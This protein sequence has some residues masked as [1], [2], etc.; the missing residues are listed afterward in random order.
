MRLGINPC[1][2]AFNTPHRADGNPKSAGKGCHRLAVRHP[3]FD[4]GDGFVRQDRIGGALASQRAVSSFGYT[5]ASVV[6]ISAE[7]EMVGPNTRTIVAAMEYVQPIGDG[8]KGVLV[9]ESVRC[10]RAP[11]QFESPISEA[12]RSRRPHPTFTGL[13]DLR[14]EPFKRGGRGN[15]ISAAVFAPSLVVHEAP[16]KGVGFTRAIVNGTSKLMWHRISNR[17]GVA[18]QA[19]ATALP[20]HCTAKLGGEPCHG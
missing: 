20:L 19:D 17:F 12:T 9:A 11:V 7:E 8:A 15:R 10:K 18:G 1:Q 13:V 14:P 2:A 6:C 16:A 4:E 3:N 5:V